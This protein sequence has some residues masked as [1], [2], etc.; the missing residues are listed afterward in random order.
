[1]PTR[2]PSA[3][4]RGDLRTADPSRAGGDPAAVQTRQN[5]PVPERIPALP[6]RTTA[7]LTEGSTTSAPPRPTQASSASSYAV[8]PRASAR[9]STRG[10]STE[11]DGMVGDDWLPR[12]RSRAIADGRHLDSQVNV[13]SARMVGPAR[14]QRRGAGLRRRP[15]VPRPR[16]LGGQPAHRLAA[17][18]RRTGRGWAGARGL[19]Q[20]PQR[21]RQVRG[22]LRR[23]RDALRQQRDGQGPAPARLQRPDRRVRSRAARR[24]RARR[25][26]G[27]SGRPDRA[28]PAE[29]STPV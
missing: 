4:R 28:A 14:R 7:Q 5:V 21:V 12:A 9:S 17:G 13:M 3:A 6:Y 8:P 16:H 11:A 18:V 1:M 23:G 19:G 20:A 10:S 26:P 15:A 2:R 27:W 29:V 25:A 24:R 22:A